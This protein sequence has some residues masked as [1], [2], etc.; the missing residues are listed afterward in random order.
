MSAVGVVSV[1]RYSN[2]AVQLAAV[3][4]PPT[5]WT[6]TETRR[7]WAAVWR[8]AEPALLFAGLRPFGACE[9]G[10]LVPE[11]RGL[12]VWGGRAA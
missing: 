10:P 4:M 9:E 8:Q 3:A 11:V 7:G 5:L 2:F 6:A 12:R 1:R